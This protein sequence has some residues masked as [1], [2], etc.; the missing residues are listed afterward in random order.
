MELA[1][2]ILQGLGIFVVV[3]A[4]IGI[5]VAG[6]FLLW[7]RRASVKQGVRELACAI[8]ADCP[9]GF[10]CVNGYCVPEQA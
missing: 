7:D 2:G 3:P 4:L 10:T 6:S 9:P 1:A 5:I 8:N